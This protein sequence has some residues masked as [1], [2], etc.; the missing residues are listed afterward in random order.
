MKN[1]LEILSPGEEDWV[2]ATSVDPNKI[3]RHVAVIMDGN[4]RWAQKRGLPRAAGHKAG[5]VPARTTIETCARM[6]VE[7]LT[8]YAFSVENWKRPKGEVETLWRLLR[9]YLNAELPNLMKN[10][11][12]LKTLGREADLPQDIAVDLRSAV[13]CTRENKGLL[14][15]VAIN[16]GGRTEI[17]DAANRAIQ[18]ARQEGTLDK[19]ELNEEILSAN[20]YNGDCPD[21]DLLIR[22]SGEL[23]ISNFL[24]WQLAY[25]EIFVTDTLWPDFGRRDLLEAVLDFQR[26][27][28]RFGGVKKGDG[29]SPKE[30]TEPFGVP[31]P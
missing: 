9:H 5:I 25:T 3:P 15:N 21:P 29:H 27:D 13:D 12:R 2:L 31:T 16:Y 8:L 24:L 19:F 7:A 17:L 11:I 30:V 1:L 28:R 4:G 23:R 22:T 6:G 20:L 14:L 26:R 18:K 10:Q